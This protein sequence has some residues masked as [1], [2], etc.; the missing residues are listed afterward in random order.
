MSDIKLDLIEFSTYAHTIIEDCTDKDE[1]M[2]Y[3][4]S[5][6]NTALNHLFEPYIAMY[7]SS[8]R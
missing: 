7:G 4:D 2:Q 5:D 1:F 8:S 3:I 6:S